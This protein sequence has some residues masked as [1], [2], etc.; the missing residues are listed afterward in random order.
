MIQA[1][2][3][4]GAIALSLF[5]L[6][7]WEKA[8]DDDDDLTP[9]ILHIDTTD[10]TPVMLHTDTFSLEKS[11]LRPASEYLFQVNICSKG[12]PIAVLLRN[13]KRRGLCFVF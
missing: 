12:I 3:M 4:K 10:L 13:K 5:L 8:H 7:Y 11:Y 6:Q 9:V 2:R 1:I